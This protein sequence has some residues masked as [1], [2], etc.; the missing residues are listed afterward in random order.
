[1]KEFSS[2]QASLLDLPLVFVNGMPF[3]AIN[4][5]YQKWT[6]PE[7]TANSCSCYYWA[8]AILCKI[9]PMS[10]IASSNFATPSREWSL[11][12]LGSPSLDAKKPAVKKNFSLSDSSL[13]S[14]HK[15]Q[16][17]KTSSPPGNNLKLSK[18]SLASETHENIVGLFGSNQVM[19]LSPRDESKAYERKHTVCLDILTKGYVH[20]FVDF[21]YITHPENQPPNED[22][23]SSNVTDEAMEML[24]ENLTSIEASVNQGDF[25]SATRSL[26]STAKYLNSLN[27][28]AFA[29]HFFLKSAEMG[30]R[31]ND[32][33]G[34]SNAIRS[35]GK[36]YETL[37]KHFM[38]YCLMCK[39][40]TRKQLNI[41]KSTWSC[42]P[43]WETKK[44]SILL[45]H[46][47]MAFTK[48]SRLISRKIMSGTKQYPTWKNVY[49]W[50]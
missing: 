33:E 8:R 42:Q 32:V 38:L 41:M 25:K 22:E 28:T 10:K 6:V 14:L 35:L 7:I 12:L 23:K 19:R 16:T 36:I 26:N 9:D 3:Y 50:L 39:G 15:P 31:T 11:P 49:K 20:S 13:P 2:T 24:K 40:I 4:S 37:G 27:K 48:F 46:F 1:M 44:N 34:A 43:T 17:S 21:F 45:V 30:K 47:L 29:A 18:A 5:S